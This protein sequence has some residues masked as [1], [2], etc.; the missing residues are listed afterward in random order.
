MTQVSKIGKLLKR[1]SLDNK[2]SDPYDICGRAKRLLN[3]WVR[4]YEME[5]KQKGQQTT[6]LQEVDRDKLQADNRGPSNS[7]SKVS[8]HERFDSFYPGHR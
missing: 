3:S 6:V 8:A 2:S 5:K 4:L 1:I 7:K